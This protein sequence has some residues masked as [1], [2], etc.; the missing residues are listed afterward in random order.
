[1]QRRDLTTD[2]L[3]VGNG[4][5]GLRAAVEAAE[6]KAK[7]ILASKLAPAQ[8]NSSSVIGG[9]GTYRRAVRLIGGWT[10]PGQTLKGGL[11][12]SYPV[13][14]TEVPSSG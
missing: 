2:V 12:T 10:I 9:W 5:A 11:R 13:R 14:G 7:V 3:V 1:M 6:R 8:P 4:G